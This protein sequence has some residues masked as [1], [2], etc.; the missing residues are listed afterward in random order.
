MPAQELIKKYC[1]DRRTYQQGHPG[2]TPPVQATIQDMEN[3]RAEAF[4]DGVAYFAAIGQDIRQLLNS[5]TPSRFFYMTAWWLGLSAFRGRLRIVDT[6]LPTNNTWYY[7]DDPNDIADF[8]DFSLPHVVQ[9]FETLLA[10]MVTKNVDVRVLPWVLPFIATEKIASATGKSDVNLHTLVSVRNLRQKIGDD[11]VVLNLLAHPLGG[12]HC[13]MVVCGDQNSMRAYT[14]GLDPEA[15]R[16]LPP[17]VPEANVA[18]NLYGT[19]TAQDDNEFERVSND[20]K[21]NTFSKPVYDVFNQIFRSRLPD[22]S[23]FVHNQSGWTYEIEL[24]RDKYEWNIQLDDPNGNLY[25][26]NLKRQ[27]KLTIAIYSWPVGGWHDV[28]VKVEGRAAGA[29]HDFFQAMWNEQLTREPE[30]FTIDQNNIISHNRNWPVVPPRPPIPLTQGT[31]RQYVQVLRTI[32]AMNFRSTPEERADVLVPDNALPPIKLGMKG[33]RL[34]IGPRAIAISAA[35]LAPMILKYERKPLSFVPHGCFEFKV[36]LKKA[37]SEAENYI[38]IADQSLYALE[39]MDWIHAR[40]SH[41]KNLK[42]ILFYGADPADPPNN[43]LSEAINNHLLEG[44]RPLFIPREQQ[45]QQPHHIV[46]WEWISNVVHCKV[47]IIDDAW[48]AIGSANCMRRS[49]YTDIELSV[50]I[51]EPPTPDNQLPGTSAQEANPGA[52]GKQAPSFVQRFRRD[53][54]AHYCRIPLDP[55][56]RD[57][58]QKENYTKLLSLEHALPLWNPGGWRTRSI[59]GS[60]TCKLRPEISRRIFPFAVSAP[61]DQK[62]YKREEPNSQE[63]F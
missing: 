45:T 15:S 3:H 22:H 47:T 38:F 60:V 55:A 51:L 61:F 1:I 52:H 31:G 29:M 35:A 7:P 2:E 20:L 56:G 53:L 46:F 30:S 33:R 63:D 50:S 36:A 49:L 37:I 25:L 28:G 43:Y 42:V 13:K 40:L 21:N 23:T 8:P 16:L 39:I 48:C 26:L 17:G 11:R 5:S 19:Y 9:N 54:W 57:D 59:R 27:D 41:K 12:A 24:R 4:I 14:S 62:A 6:T 18:Q 58:T 34:K 10:L 44:N 32:P